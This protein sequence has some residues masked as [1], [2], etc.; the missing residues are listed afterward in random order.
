LAHG[1]D[2]DAVLLHDLFDPDVL[3]HPQLRIEPIL[4]LPHLLR[5]LGLRELRKLL[6]DHAQL[7]R[8]HVFE[9]RLGYVLAHL[10]LARPAVVPALDDRIGVLDQ[11]TTE[12]AGVRSHSS[13]PTHFS[14]ISAQPA[15]PSHARHRSRRLKRSGA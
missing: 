7:L 12:R 2:R 4:D 13:P 5:A 1:F 10:A 11:L 14:F 3:V 6:A 9:R 8:Q 15:L